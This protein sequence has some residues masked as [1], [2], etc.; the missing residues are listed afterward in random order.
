[1]HAQNPARRQ[2]LRGNTKIIPE[3]VEE[4][5]RRYTFTVPVRCLAE[6]LVYEGVS[7]KAGERALMY[8]PA[9]DLDPK[10]F[11]N[12]E[13]CDL[14]REEKTHIAFGAGPHRCLGSHLAR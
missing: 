7:M 9:A 5:L 4:M 3:T 6:D 12:P 13:S 8:D 14:D 1:H 2:E 11:K 10:Q